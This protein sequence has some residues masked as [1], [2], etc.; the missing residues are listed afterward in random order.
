MPQ[1]SVTMAN[2]I[3]R[4]P[5]DPCVTP[6][7]WPTMRRVACIA[8]TFTALLPFTLYAA[9]VHYRPA[10]ALW[11]IT[12]VALAYRT[13]HNKVRSLPIVLTSLP[14]IAAAL[15]LL[16]SRQRW[17]VLWHLP[18]TDRVF[19]LPLP[20]PDELLVC[21]GNFIEPFAAS[22]SYHFRLGL[23]ILSAMSQLTVALSAFIVSRLCFSRFRAP[24]QNENTRSSPTA[25]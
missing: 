6:K 1:A 2:A 23:A 5:Y 19:P 9:R 18:V 20:Y 12:A 14:V 7:P 10:T 16:W 13:S 21:F 4:N 25:A 17:L 22:M 15:F 11:L 8:V 24:Q 3:Q